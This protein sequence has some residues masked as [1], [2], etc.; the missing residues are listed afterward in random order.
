MQTSEKR[1]LVL[2]FPECSLTYLKLIKLLHCAVI[3]LAPTSKPGNYASA[4]TP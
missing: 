4:A 1:E 2:I 3:G